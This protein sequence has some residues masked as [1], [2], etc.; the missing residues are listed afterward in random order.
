MYCMYLFTDGPFCGRSSFPRA[1]ESRRRWK[2]GFTFQF[3][4]GDFL[5]DVQDLLRDKALQFAE[6][7]LLKNRP[8]LFLLSGDAL[9]ED[10]LSNFRTSL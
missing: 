2:P 3:V 10:Q 8:Y 6:R 7:L 9:A 4:L 5:D 1:A